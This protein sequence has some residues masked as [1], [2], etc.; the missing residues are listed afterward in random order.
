MPGGNEAP[1]RSYRCRFKSNFAKKVRNRLL[2]Y[3]IDV[4]VGTS[5]FD[6][7]RTSR[8][9][10]VVPD[11]VKTGKTITGEREVALAAA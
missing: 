7:E 4:Q 11:H 9:R 2:I 5:G 3:I 1:G 10:V 8:L 6:R